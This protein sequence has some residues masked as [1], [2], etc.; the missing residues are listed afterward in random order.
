MYIIRF[1]LAMIAFIGSFLG[2][3][4]ALNY[5]VVIGVI[6]AAG[7]ILGLLVHLDEVNNNHHR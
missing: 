2:V 5:D 1:C 4:V 6:I 3:I 7:C